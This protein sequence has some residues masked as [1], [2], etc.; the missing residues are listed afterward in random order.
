MKLKHESIKRLHKLFPHLTADKIN[1]GVFCGPSVLKILE[2]KKFYKKLPV[3]HQE[4]L[5]ALK[6]VINNF[7]GNVSSKNAA[8]NA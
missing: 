7:L 1:G 5:L 3:K 8:L 2:D 6:D 4:A